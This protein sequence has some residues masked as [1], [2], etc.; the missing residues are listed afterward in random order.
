MRL[1][2]EDQVAT[3]RR[4]NATR[5]KEEVTEARVSHTFGSDIG[6]R[7]PLELFGVG[8]YLFLFALSVT[9]SS[10]LATVGIILYK[11]YC[12]NTVLSAA[13]W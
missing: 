2:L 11:L 3:D 10:S 9:A 7:P 1:T 5:Q 13:Q 6:A 4:T 12:T 8:A